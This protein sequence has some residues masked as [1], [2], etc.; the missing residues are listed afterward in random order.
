ML[1][2]V[3]D[4]ATD[5]KGIDEATDTYDTIDWLIKNVRTTTAASAWTAFPTTAT[6]SPW[7]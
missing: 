4:P 1:H 3:H 5:P 7:A 2:P 6:S